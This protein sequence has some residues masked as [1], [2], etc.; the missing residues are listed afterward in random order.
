MEG[1]G[2]GREPTWPGGEGLRAAGW[3]HGRGF[4]WSLTTPLAALASTVSRA[5][6]MPSA[7]ALKS[8]GLDVW[9]WSSPSASLV[10]VVADEG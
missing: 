2:E 7:P 10:G 5:L 1:V 4:D 6:S 8:A 3:A 9:V